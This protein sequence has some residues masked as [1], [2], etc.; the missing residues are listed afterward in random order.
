MFNLIISIIAIALVVVLAGASLY[1]GGEAFNRGSEE[2][3]ASTYI[4]QAQQIQAATVLYKAN[5]GGN[6]ADIAK[7]VADKY[8]AG[9]PKVA[10][11]TGS[12]AMTAQH[13]FVA[14]EVSSSAKDG[15]TPNIC[16]TITANGSGV[17]KCS[18][19]TDTSAATLNTTDVV[20]AA[21]SVAVAEDV[22][23]WMAL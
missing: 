1:Y 23:V 20:A 9:A 4:N 12:W 8:M 16:A 15:I 19:G 13:I 21:A 5:V 3:K 10:T 17:V 18:K 6:P 2:A 11:G 22:V 14:Q 7:L